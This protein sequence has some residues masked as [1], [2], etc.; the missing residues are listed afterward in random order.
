MYIHCYMT[1]YNYRYIYVYLSV[2]DVIEFVT[3]ISQGT[4]PHRNLK[5]VPCVAYPFL[6]KRE[7]INF[8]F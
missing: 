4:N 3:N 6:L 2:D 5:C 8:C 7:H 1:L